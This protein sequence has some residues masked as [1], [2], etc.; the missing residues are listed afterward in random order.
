ME[1]YLKDTDLGLHTDLYK[2][3][4]DYITNLRIVDIE[5]INQDVAKENVNVAFEKYRLGSINDIELRE[6]QKK[7]IDAQYQ[8]LVSQF[9]A[10]KAE[11]ELLRIS[12]ELMRVLS[13]EF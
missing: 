2:I 10:K 13:L 7:Y 12:G 9:Q 8:L 3:Y 11:V 1:N 4:N 5:L 6:T